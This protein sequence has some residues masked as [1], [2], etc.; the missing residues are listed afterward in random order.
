MPA[1]V[2]GRVEAAQH[3][4]QVG[5]AV[6]RD[7]QHLALDAPVEALDHA[8]SFRRVGTR[9]AMLHTVPLAGGLKRI[10]REA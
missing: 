4:L 5:V 9:L 7:P 2:V 10:G 6:E 1:A 8:V 3:D